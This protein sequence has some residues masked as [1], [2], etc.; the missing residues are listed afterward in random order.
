MFGLWYVAKCPSI[1]W[2]ATHMPAN[3]IF[4][5]VTIISIVE[6]VTTLSDL[7]NIGPRR[8]C[9]E[10]ITHVMRGPTAGSLLSPSCTG[11]VG[12]QY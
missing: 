8:G 3:F 2:I 10:G 4:L 5:T 7:H 11:P 12:K 9:T 6:D 1:C